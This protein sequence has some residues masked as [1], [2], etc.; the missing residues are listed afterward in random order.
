MQRTAMWL[1]TVAKKGKA[2]GRSG[3]AV[4]FVGGGEADYWQQTPLHSKSMKT[5]HYFLATELR[6]SVANGGWCEV[7]SGQQTAANASAQRCAGSEREWNNLAVNG[8]T[9]LLVASC[10]RHCLRPGEPGEAIKL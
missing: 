2:A 1:L 4:P 6:K 8:M 9:A 7:S 3:Q 5:V 10:R